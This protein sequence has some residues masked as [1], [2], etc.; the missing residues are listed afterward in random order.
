MFFIHNCLVDLSTE[1]GEFLGGRD[2]MGEIF[3]DIYKER[4][5]DRAK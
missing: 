2:G 5:G 3:I 4:E 1:R